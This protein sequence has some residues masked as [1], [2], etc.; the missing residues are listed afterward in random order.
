MKAGVSIVSIVGD[1][2]IVAVQ[3]THVPGG[4]TNGSREGRTEQRAKR[5]QGKMAAIEHRKY[6]AGPYLPY[7]R[8]WAD[9]LP[10]KI[11]V[12]AFLKRGILRG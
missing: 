9:T 4:K 6:L 5:R 10:G 1:N 12:K 7:L 8:P 2:I 11:T 3:Q